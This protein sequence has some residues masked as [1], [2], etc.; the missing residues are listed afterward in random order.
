M[1]PHD[2]AEA[3]V[4]GRYVGRAVFKLT[5]ALT[6]LAGAV[7]Y[8]QFSVSR[9]ERFDTP[10]SGHSSRRVLSKALPNGGCK[11]TYAHLTEN[12]IPQTWQAS[13]PGSG[14]RMTWSLVEALTGIKTNDDFDSHE[15]GYENVVAVKTHYPVKDA[16]NRF[17]DLD[18]T[19]SRAIVILRNPINAI[20]SY[21]NLQYGE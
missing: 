5:T 7:F 2:Q 12:P 18:K 14:S 3:L 13:F 6:L 19:F 15:R 17:K 21:F 20:P 9:H 10:F 16:Y 8:V 4:G 1:E 11:V